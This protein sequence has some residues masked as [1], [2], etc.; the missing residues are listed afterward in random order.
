MALDLVT[1]VAILLGG[2]AGLRGGEI[3]ALQWTEVDL[4]KR[5]LAVTRS[6]WHGVMGTPKHDR[7]RYVPLTRRLAATLT[8]SRH[9]RGPRVLCQAD[10]TPLTGI[11]IYDAVSRAARR[12]GLNKVGVH[13]LRHSFCSHL[14][15]RGAPVRAIQELAGHANLS[16][17]QR[18]MHLSPPRSTA[19]FDCWT[20][21]RVERAGDGVGPGVIGCL[22]DRF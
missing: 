1:T 8:A 21:A 20:M 19:R 22:K 7:I 16:T 17:T 4:H 13:I 10:G 5:Q 9:L 6:E 3:A 12:A 2:D 18:Y 14:A 11:M 15:M